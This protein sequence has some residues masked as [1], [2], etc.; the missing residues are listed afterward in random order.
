MVGYASSRASAFG[1]VRYGGA[2]KNAGLVNEGAN[3]RLEKGQD[4]PKC[5]RIHRRLFAHG[6][7]ILPALQ[8]DLSL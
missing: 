8:F 2:M 6:P 3:S 5:R 7:V 1:C 4:R